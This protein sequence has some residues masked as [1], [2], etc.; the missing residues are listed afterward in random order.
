[1]GKKS[2]IF[3]SHYGKDDDNVQRLKQR[4]R[5]AGHDIRN[6]SIDSTKHNNK[7]STDSDRSI[8]RMLKELDRA[9]IIEPNTANIITDDITFLGPYLSIKIPAGIWKIAK[10]RKNT[11]PN[12]P[13]LFGFMLKSCIKL[14]DNTPKDV[15]RNWLTV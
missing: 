5:D 6:S 11:P 8:K 2:N 3:I 10:E 7:K 1:M 9:N 14:G 15:R 13:I 4:L 12:K